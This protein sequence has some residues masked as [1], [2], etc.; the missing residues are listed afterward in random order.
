[1]KTGKQI[2]I[3][4]CFLLTSQV[5]F[6]QESINISGKVFDKETSKPIFSAR[7]VLGGKVTFT[8]P[9]GYFIFKDIENKSRNIQ[10]YHDSYV[11]TQKEIFC[12]EEDCYVEIFLSEENPL[13]EIVVTGTRTEKTIANTPVLTK[14]ITEKEIEQVGALTAFD[15]IE[16]VV[17]G[18]QF[19]PDAHGA[20]MSIQGL[21][22]DYVLVLVDGERL[23]GE[24]RGNVNFNRIAASDIKRIEIV[25][26]A[27]SVLY[28]SNAI[29]GVINIITK[30]VSKPVEG[31]IKSRYTHSG[32]WHHSLS[33]GLK[34]ER[35]SCKINGFYNHSHGYDLSPE[36]P[37]Y[38]TANPYQDFSGGGKLHYSPTSKWK[39]SAHGSYFLHESKNPPKS[40][41]STH[42]KYRN[43]NGGAS[44]IYAFNDE[45]TLKINGNSDIYKA[46]TIFEKKENEEEKHSDFSYS[47]L[48]ITDNYSLS[49]KWQFVSGAEINFEHVYS[50]SLFGKDVEES[51][52]N[53][54]SKDFNGFLQVDGTLFDKL[55]LLAGIRYTC[56]SVFKSHFAP[57]LSAMYKISDFKFRGTGAFG[58]KSPSLKELYYNF[59]HQGM[60]WIY[61][62]ENLK[63]EN[64]KYFSL[65]GEYSKRNINFSITARHNRI[66]DKI[67]MV[68]VMNKTTNKMEIRYQNISEAVL[69]GFDSRLDCRMFSGKVK[70]RVSYSFTDAED[71]STGLKL[72][73]ISRHTGTAALTFQK[74]D[75]T[76]PF[77]FTLSCRAVSPR[78]YQE[79]QEDPATGKEVIMREESESYSIW[80]LS[81]SQKIPL[82]KSFSAKLQVGIDNLFDYVD[83][84]KNSEITPGRI[85]RLG[86]SIRF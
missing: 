39:L 56:H 36:T 69:Q 86:L 81:Y 65:S 29:G 51:Q 28:G 17:P 55:E 26:G 50:S 23:V 58:Y 67:D 53:K 48:L 72:Y 82:H 54:S 71:Q 49:D 13:D 25:N 52:K 30:N 4:I 59:D 47:T 74:N 9:E 62:N 15:A 42:K 22:N 76:T 61:G 18:I 5:S 12:K 57:K 43:Y 7:V 21:D 84:E 35:F 68:S 33:T 85:Y 1:M 40:L 31:E 64:S 24:T 3:L 66:S 63:P 80:K 83:L 38:F 19:S 34:K 60:F 41:L 44:M 73:G 77:A 75:I 10:V 16:C 32:T 8:N 46:F 14:I 37:E 78:L 70:L 27:S 45:H 79:K 6:G 20:N 11:S 2:L